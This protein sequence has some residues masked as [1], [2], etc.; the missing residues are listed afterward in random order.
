MADKLNLGDTFPALALR[1][2]GGGTLTVPD[3]LA[4]PYA[5]IMFYR[6]HW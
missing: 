3:D 6:G 4:T 1:I 5:I 2:A